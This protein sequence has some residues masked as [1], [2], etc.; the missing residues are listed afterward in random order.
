MNEF[1]TVSKTLRRVF[2]R[3]N[4]T[5]DNNSNN[6][7]L[8]FIIVIEMIRKFLVTLFMMMFMCS[9][10]V[11]YGASLSISDCGSNTTILHFTDYHATEVKRNKVLSF[12]SGDA[13]LKENITAGKASLLAYRN[14]VGYWLFL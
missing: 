4:S 12:W 14:D 7:Q 2:N 5:L 11:D 9:V 13:L 8:F 6:H 3:G 1:H 10:A